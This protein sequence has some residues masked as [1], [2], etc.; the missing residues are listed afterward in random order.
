MKSRKLP[1]PALRRRILLTLFVFGILSL[2][3]TVK[4]RRD[5]T[6]PEGYLPRNPVG[7]GSYDVPLTAQRAGTSADMI[8]TVGEQAPDRAQILAA[9][10]AAEQELSAALP[11]GAAA[12]HVTQDLPFLDQLKDSPVSVLWISEAP[13]ILD[14]AGTIGENIPAD[15]ASVRVRAVLSY[16]KEVRE[17]PYSFRVYPADTAIPEMLAKQLRIAADRVNDPSSDRL[18]LPSAL[19]GETVLWQAKHSHSGLILFLLGLLASAVMLAGFFKENADAEKKLEKALLHD[20]PDLIDTLVLLLSAGMSSRGAVGKMALDYKAGLQ[21]GG[22][23][24]PGYELF[25]AAHQDMQRG[26]L[27]RDAYVRLG[28]SCHVSRYK[29]LSSLLVQNLEKGGASMHAIL[30]REAKDAADCRL[31]EARILGEEAGTKLLA[32]M[33]LMLGIVLVFLTVPAF[34]TFL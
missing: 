18:L 16:E 4:E 28:Q 23:K 34:M 17:I 31:K 3:I 15:G 33:L 30:L 10:D 2:L 20:Y 26:V 9:I 25:L 27:E 22:M 32:P 29:T 5:D 14:H 19:E 12:E 8:L 21:K 6:V 7:G 1:P 24:R 11:R 13:E